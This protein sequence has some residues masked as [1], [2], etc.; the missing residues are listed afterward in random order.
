MENPVL[1]ESI[2]VVFSSCDVDVDA[3]VDPPKN[4]FDNS[5]SVLPTS[6]P[7]N[8]CE[9]ELEL[10]GCLEIEVEEYRGLI[11][12]T[13]SATGSTSLASGNVVVLFLGRACQ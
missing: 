13:C 9:S 5:L 1:E 10:V 8:S 6:T 4:S 7:K 12:E 11:L 2:V 3:D